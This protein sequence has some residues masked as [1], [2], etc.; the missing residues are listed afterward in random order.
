MARR[1]APGKRGG[2]LRAALSAT[3]PAMSGDE[4]SNLATMFF[5]AA[6]AGGAAPFLWEREGGAFAP[7]SWERVADQVRRLAAFLASVGVEAGDRVVLVA[8]NGRRWVVGDL[9]IMAVGAAAVPAYTTN[10]VALHEHVLADSGARLALHGGGA[11]ARRLL[12]ACAA[13]GVRAVGWEEAMAAPGDGAGEVEARAARLGRG[14]RACI[15]YTSGTGG[16]PKGVVLSHGAILS[17]IASI[18][19][20]FAPLLAGRETFLSFLPLAHSY[21]HTA[22][23]HFPISIGAEI[24]Y[25]ASAQT[26]AADMAEARP[27]IVT[28]VPRLLETLRQR[29]PSAAGRPGSLRRRLLERAAALGAARAEGRRLG[30]LARLQ[31]RALE[32]AV[33]AA[34]RRRFG[35]RLKALVSGGAAL[36]PD[37]GLFLAGLGLPVLQG[38]GQ[39]E[40]APVVS[41][42][43]P[44]AVRMAT[45]G[46]PLPQVEVA[47][48]DDGEILVKGGL[49]MDGYWNDEAATARALAGGWLHTGDIGSIDGD[50]FL[51]ITDR[52]K[53]MIVTAGGENVSPARVEGILCQEEAIAQAMVAGDGRPW[54]AA[55]LVAAD[56]ADGEAVAAAMA[57]ANAR[58]SAIERI[59]RWTLAREAFTVDNG[60]MTPTMKLRRHAVGAIYGEALASLYRRGRAGGEGEESDGG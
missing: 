19:S 56:G 28:C 38:Y 51:A 49:L 45:V 16:L 31:D 21:E 4:R 2:S 14:D 34:I 10:T 42:N 40:A 47:I 43:L 18:G 46:R 58:L 17:N 39:T 32:G 9:A 44:G 33:R 26:L 54:L 41:C 13:T 25:A 15:I 8:E 27:T 57:R 59:R 7:A 55:L 37:V 3:L 23:L 29:L 11:P 6:A 22:G 52:K 50:G 48:A 60:L 12:P 5:A 35:G 1:P 20:A 36:A 24:Y 30:P 53:D